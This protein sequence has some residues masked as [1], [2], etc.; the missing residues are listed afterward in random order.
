MVANSQIGFALN[1]IANF[2]APM[3]APTSMADIART[4]QLP[5]QVDFALG[6]F[7]VDV[8][9]PSDIGIIEQVHEPAMAAILGSA[10]HSAHVFGPEFRP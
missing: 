3:F 4:Q 1:H 8:K 7:A 9:R 10:L 2:S 6:I 5:K